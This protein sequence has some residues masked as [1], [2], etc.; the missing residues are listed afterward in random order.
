MNHFCLELNS[1][2]LQLSLSLPTILE[3]CSLEL[4]RLK[5]V[6]LCMAGNSEP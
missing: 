3:Y 4:A 6:K 5:E 2:K 1:A